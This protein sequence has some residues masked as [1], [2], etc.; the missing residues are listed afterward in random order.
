MW[1]PADSRL[2][3][4][5]DRTIRA[6]LGWR[7]GASAV[8]SCRGHELKAS[9]MRPVRPGRILG[10]G[11]VVHRVG[12]IAYLEASLTDTDGALIAT[13]SATARVIPFDSAESAPCP[14]LSWL[15]RTPRSR[16][17]AS[18]LRP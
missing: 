7:V 2:G 1:T 3:R 18:L 17:P 13:A 9:F 4:R 11:R 14:R 8:A 12:D 15:L 10:R 16:S 5:D 6:V